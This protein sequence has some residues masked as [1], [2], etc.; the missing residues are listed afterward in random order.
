MGRFCFSPAVSI[1]CSLACVAVLRSFPVRWRFHRIRRFGRIGFELIKTLEIRGSSLSVLVTVANRAKGVRTSFG[2]NPRVRG[3]RGLPEP[4]KFLGFGGPESRGKTQPRA[5]VQI[6]CAKQ[7]T[8]F[9]FR[10]NE[11]AGQFV[12][13]KI[14]N[15]FA[16]RLA[17]GLVIGLI[18]YIAPQLIGT[19]FRKPFG[20][21][22]QAG[23]GYY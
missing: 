12:C 15:C 6:R 8:N 11:Y 13:Q 9:N 17:L 21:Y 22:H 3:P 16:H 5:Q 18:L 4:H 1:K 20:Q 19:R 23:G 2:R 7:L 10:K 14:L